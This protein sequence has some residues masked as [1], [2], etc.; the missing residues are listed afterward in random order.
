MD[1]KTTYLWS[2]RALTK[3]MENFLVGWNF[4]GK[5]IQMKRSKSKYRWINGLNTVKKSKTCTLQ[6]LII[7]KL[8]FYLRSS[9]FL[10]FKTKIFP[11]LPSEINHILEV[12]FKIPNGYYPSHTW[13]QKTHSFYSSKS[14]QSISKNFQSKYPELIIIINIF[15]RFLIQI[16]CRH[17]QIIIQIA[18]VYL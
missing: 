7:L 3:V 14:H 12:N 8:G 5:S 6:L 9:I 4:V 15:S 18:Q 16:Y 1:E 13:L 17:K 2:Y 11:Y 10:H